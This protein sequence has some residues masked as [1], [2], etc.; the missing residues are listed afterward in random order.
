VQEQAKIDLDFAAALRHFLRQTGHLMVARPR[1]GDRPLRVQAASRPPELSTL[2]TTTPATPS[3]DHRPG[4]SVLEASA[5]VGV[6]SQRLCGRLPAM[7]GGLTPSADECRRARC[8]CAAA[9]GHSFKRG[10]GC[11]QWPR[12]ASWGA[13]HLRD[14]RRGQGDK[15]EILAGR[16]PASSRQGPSSHALAGESACS[17]RHGHQH[18]RGSGAVAEPRSVGRSGVS[19]SAASG[20]PPRLVR[21]AVGVSC[22][23]WRT[24]QRQGRQDAKGAKDCLLQLSGPARVVG[25]VVAA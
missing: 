24:C 9:P 7:R 12:R 19:W 1:P 16:T 13:P 10:S 18:H 14:A 3:P 8:R 20:R 5:L 6:K 15:G 4:W 11:A 21:R 17:S 2:H 22:R 23:P 25:R